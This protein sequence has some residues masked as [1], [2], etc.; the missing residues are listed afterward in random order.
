MEEKQKEGDKE[1]EVEERER[2]V[3]ELKT[4]LQHKERL[5]HVSEE[6]RFLDFLDP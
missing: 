5:L 1:S 6:S 2:T 3:R 4:R